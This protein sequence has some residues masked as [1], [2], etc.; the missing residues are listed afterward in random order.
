M[1]KPLKKGDITAHLVVDGGEQ[2]CEFYKNA[3]GAEIHGIHKTPDGKVM[4]AELTVGGARLM[5]ADAFPG[6]SDRSAKVPD[7][8]PGYFGRDRGRS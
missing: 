5:L 8:L 3:F 1:S 6:F 4:H 2:A 7:E